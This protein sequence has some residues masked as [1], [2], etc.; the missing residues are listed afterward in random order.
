MSDLFEGRPIPSRFETISQWSEAQKRTWAGE[1]RD[2][3]REGD[4][5]QFEER[6]LGKLEQIATENPEFR[7]YEI[8]HV[9]TGSTMFEGKKLPFDTEE[10]DV[11]RAALNLN[12]DLLTEVERWRMNLFR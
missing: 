3:W 5:K 10:Q 12:A 6:F 7:R 9:L 11:L 4:G 1:T 2:Y 8:F